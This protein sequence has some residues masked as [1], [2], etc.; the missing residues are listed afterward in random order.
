MDSSPR[1]S[2]G[3]QA[4]GEEEVKIHREKR[5]IPD[6][7]RGTITTIKRI[8]LTF[9]KDGTLKNLLK[10]LEGLDPQSTV[11]LGLSADAD[12]ADNA[13]VIY[14]SVV[15][16]MDPKKAEKGRAAHMAALAAE[17]EKRAK[18]AAIMQAL[19]ARSRG[20]PQ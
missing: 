4:R 16:K 2:R 6:Y 10:K 11:Y 14:S 15:A 19:R 17:A 12:N 8:E 1:C 20:E 13:L 3:D 7:I 5:V 9:E 18:S